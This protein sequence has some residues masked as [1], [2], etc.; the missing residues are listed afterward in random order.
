MPVPVSVTERHDIAARLQMP[1]SFVDRPLVRGDDD[2]SRRWASRRCAFIAR[3]RSASSS[4]LASAI[5]L[6]QAER[7]A[8]LDLHGRA[9]RALQQIRHAADQVGDVDGLEFQLL[10]ARESQHALRQCRAALRA[11]QRVVEK[12]LSCGSCGQAPFQKFEAAQDR[13]QKIVEVMR[14]AAGEV[15]DG[16]HLLRLD[17]G[18]PRALQLLLRAFLRSVMSRVILAKPMSLAV[19]SWIASMTTFAQKLRAVLADA[20]AFLLEPSFRAAPSQARL[21]AVRPR[22]LR[23]VEGRKVLADDLFRLVALDP[24]RARIPA[25]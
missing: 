20:Q 9:E 11:L 13:H 12:L 6:R 18:F 1:G 4:W 2:A 22:D 21:P 25:R 24:L 7:K 8:G 23:R 17:K 5:T 3:L 15:A 16:F 14:D 10:P 19:A